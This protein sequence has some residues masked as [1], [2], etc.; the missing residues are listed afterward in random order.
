MI[1]ELLSNPTEWKPIFTMPAHAPRR[2]P[3]KQWEEDR[4]KLDEEEGS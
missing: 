1:I 4:K 3:M 2:Y